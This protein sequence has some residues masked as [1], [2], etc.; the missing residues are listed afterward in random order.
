MFSNNYIVKV[1]LI[2]VWI[3]LISSCSTNK[4]E[5]TPDPPLGEF[6]VLGSR[7]DMSSPNRYNESLFCAHWVLYK[8]YEEVYID[9]M[10]TSVKEVKGLDVNN[11]TFRE[12]HYME[13]PWGKWLYSHNCIMWKSNSHYDGYEIL[14]VSNRVLIWRK[15]V[16]FSNAPW[17]AY[18][19]NP[20]GEHHF[21]RYEYHRQ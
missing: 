10:L 9:G 18:H 12:D 1:L 2:P 15:D 21:Y 16:P 5:P 14:D 6:S 20:K 3:M 13:D 17:Q 7:L 4:Q 19:K 11:Y 8:T